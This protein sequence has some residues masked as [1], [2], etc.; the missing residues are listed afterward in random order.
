[1]SPKKSRFWFPVLGTMMSSLAFGLAFPIPTLGG[2]VPNWQ[3]VQPS[4]S[5][6]LSPTVAKAPIAVAFVK[7]LAVTSAS[8]PNAELLLPVTLLTSALSPMAVLRKPVVFSRS[9]L[10]PL[11]VL[12]LPKVFKLSAR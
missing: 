10:S 2:L 4:A 1:V 8:S 7:L 5:A 12:S 3:L 6:L 11:A 9:A